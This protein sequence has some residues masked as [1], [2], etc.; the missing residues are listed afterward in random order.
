VSESGTTGKRRADTPRRGGLDAG[1]RRLRST[2]ASAIWLVAVVAAL[3]LAVGALLVALRFNL[4]NPVI[5]TI[6]SI[7]GR[8]DLGELKSFDVAKDAGAGAREDAVVKSV[9]VNWG[10][11]AVVY[12]VVGKVLDRVI[13]PRG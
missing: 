7:A 3:V 8:I 6:T 1:S 12:L 4:D 9:L 5:D 10:I 11:A 2:L 13:R